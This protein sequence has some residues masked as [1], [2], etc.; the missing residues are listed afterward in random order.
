MYSA[1]ELARRALAGWNAHDLDTVFADWDTAIVVRPDRYYPD[2]EELVG[3][4]AV[5]RFWEDQRDAMGY[6]QMDAVE[7]HDLGDRCLSR[8]RQHVDTRSGIRSSYEWSFLTTAR[9]GKIVTIEFF[10]DRDHGLQAAGVIEQK[11]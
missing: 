5:R 4:A 6:G 7:T 8:V 3:R 10:L 2:S 11:S 9:A 1:A